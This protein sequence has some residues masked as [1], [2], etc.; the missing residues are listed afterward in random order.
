[1]IRAIYEALDGMGFEKG[2]ILEPSMGVGNFFGML[3]DSMLG[4]R[5]GYNIVAEACG[6]ALV[7]LVDDKEIPLCREHVVVLH[8]ALV[9]FPW[10]VHIDFCITIIII[11]GN[12]P[13]R[14]I[15]NCDIILC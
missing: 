11:P 8:D 1:M 6:D 2:N 3:P 13:D 10:E 12:F 15:I 9:F 5:I 7:C 14:A 4:S